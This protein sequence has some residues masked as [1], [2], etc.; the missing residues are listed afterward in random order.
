MARCGASGRILYIETYS[1]GAKR[2][3][4]FM[5]SGGLSFMALIAI[6]VT[7][8]LRHFGI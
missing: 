2:S 7:F 1:R 3:A 5:L 6:V 8:A 4:G